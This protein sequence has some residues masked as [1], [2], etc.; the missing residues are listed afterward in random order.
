MERDNIAFIPYYH[1]DYPKRLLQ[2]PDSPFGIYVKG[3][4]LKDSERSVA[5]VGARNCSAYGRYVADAFARELAKEGVAVISGM[6]KGIDGVAQ[7]GALAAGGRTYAVLGCGVDICYPSSHEKLYEEICRTG[8]VLSTY[9]PKTAPTP[10]HFPPR[11]R[12]ISGLSD[13]VLVVEARQKSGTLIT[14]DMALEQGREVYVVP[15]RITDRLSDGCNRLLLQGAGMALSPAQMIKELSETVWRSCPQ[16]E[17]Q[18]EADSCVK[19]VAAGNT[20]TGITAAEKCS[21]QEKALLSLLDFYPISMEQIY[22]M[23]QNEKLLCGLKLP[24]LMELL[25]KLIARDMVAD[26]GGYYGLKKPI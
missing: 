3:R 9:P 7:N 24:Q 19:G 11:N 8:G 25:L 20:E 13:A 12:I 26:E 23:A 10:K 17:T 14:V 4:M 15:G 5:I 18:K 21:G 1:P 2:I 16:G 6:A 22:I